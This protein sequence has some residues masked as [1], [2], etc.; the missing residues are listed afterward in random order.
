M[1]PALTKTQINYF[2]ERINAAKNIRYGTMLEESNRMLPSFDADA[3]KIKAIASGTVELK[4]EVLHGD[5]LAR[6]WTLKD[7]YPD[8]PS[9]CE[10][11]KKRVRLREKIS[12]QYSS[13]MLLGEWPVALNS[14]CERILDE[15]VL[16][17]IAPEEV[18]QVIEQVLT[19]R[20]ADYW[21]LVR[22]AEKPA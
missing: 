17:I 11:E 8:P 20:P 18:P 16:G 5:K 14:R 19:W 10:F 6:N 12:R 21:P 22:E 15:L 3:E 7:A 1:M 9:V 2:R 13:G 4:E